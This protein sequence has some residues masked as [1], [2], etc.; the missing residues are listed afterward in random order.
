MRRPSFL[1]IGAQ[2]SGTTWVS[3]RLKQHPEVFLV[4]GTYFFDD[5][6]QFAKG[7][8]WYFRFFAEAG[9]NQVIG[10][11]T[12]SYLWG[13]KFTGCDQ[14]GDVPK[15]VRHVLP[16]VRLIAVLR[17]PVTRAISQFNHSIRSCKLSP[18]TNIDRVLTW[19]DGASSRHLGLLERG[20]YFRQ[21]QRWLDYF[22]HDR[23]RVLVFERDI[24]QRP[25]ECLDSLCEFL[26]INRTFQFRTVHAR[27]NQRLCK[28]ELVLKYYMPGVRK[29]LRPLLQRLPQDSF[30]ARPETYDFLANYYASENGRL[31]RE[32]GL[33]LSCWRK[34]QVA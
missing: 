27:E 13:E 14:P 6:R 31:E 33:D 25:V 2:K 20:L 11:K 24:V 15:R 5:P 22:P 8:D 4:H 30:Q 9:P 23:V 7:T 28:A 21:L 10:E 17:D 34:K 16:D 19:T 1:I 29:V 3:Y 26:G 18:F 12:P 32:L